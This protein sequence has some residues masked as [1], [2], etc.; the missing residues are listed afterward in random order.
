MTMEMH[1]PLNESMSSPDEAK[2]WALLNCIPDPEVPA[3]SI[4]ELGVVRSVTVDG[5]SVEVAMTPTYSGC[6]ALKAMEDEVQR[7]LKE[8]GY[9]PGIRIVYKPAWTTE[10]MSEST[11]AKLKAYGIAPPPRLSFEHLHPL[12]KP[13]NEP[14]RCPFCDS[15]NTTITS[16]FGSTACKAL[17]ACHQCH[18][19]FEQFKCI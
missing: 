19:P 1:I 6:P 14:V 5:C 8:N 13:G 11:K 18:Q 9:E 2:V 7:V 3:I 16:N 17:Y 10:W 12:A 4:V 15:V